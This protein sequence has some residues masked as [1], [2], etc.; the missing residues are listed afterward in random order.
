MMMEK[1][2]R[3]IALRLV[4]A[5]ILLAVSVYEFIQGKIEV[6]AAFFA[7]FLIAVDLTIIKM[8]FVF[9]NVEQIEKLGNII[10][11]ITNE[12]EKD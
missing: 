8:E 9:F 7:S 4:F 10:R 12:N 5:V 1:Y 6:A 3:K 2:K 11:G